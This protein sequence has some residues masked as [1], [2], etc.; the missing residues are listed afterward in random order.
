MHPLP[1]A[2]E[3]Y[4]YMYISMVFIVFSDWILGDEITHNNTRSYGAYITRFPMTGYVGIGGPHPCRTGTPEVGE[5]SWIG[6]REMG[7]RGPVGGGFY[8]CF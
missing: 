8:L 5:I 4:I 6:S 7:D 1:R 2:L 3:V